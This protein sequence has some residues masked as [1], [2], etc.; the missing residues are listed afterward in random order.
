MGP[1]ADKPAPPTSLNLLVDDVLEIILAALP[2]NL[3][4]SV[5]SRLCRR[6]HTMSEAHIL[7]RLK[8]QCFWDEKVPSWAS[9]WDS[10]RCPTLF[11]YLRGFPLTPDDIVA[12]YGAFRPNPDPTIVDVFREARLSPEELSF[13]VSRIQFVRNRNFHPEP[14]A[15]TVGRILRKAGVSKDA[16]RHLAWSHSNE[17]FTDLVDRFDLLLIALDLAMRAQQG[18]EELLLFADIMEDLV[19]SGLYTDPRLPNPG[20]RGT[21]AAQICALILS[22]FPTV[23]AAVF[24][25]QIVVGLDG[26][27]S[28]ESFRTPGWKR[29]VGVMRW[30]QARDGIAGRLAGVEHR[31]V[32]EQR[33]AKASELV[34]LCDQR[35]D[36]TG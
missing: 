16:V 5:V 33:V 3:V 4:A 13:L 1:A 15:V 11:R 23:M 9:S 10:P 20:G 35:V 19:L 18:T 36:T 2:L 29:A 34:A 31:R 32:D 17:Q 6:M 24:V 27:L 30:M 25:K 28:L 26:D 21:C 7:R 8:R 22:D 14:V 12:V